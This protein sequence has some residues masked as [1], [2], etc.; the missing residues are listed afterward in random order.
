MRSMRLSV[1]QNRGGGEILQ[2]G[3]SYEDELVMPYDI[4]P[5]RPPISCWINIIPRPTHYWPVGRS[6]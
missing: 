3:F 2:Q 6:P 1:L 5:R 4:D